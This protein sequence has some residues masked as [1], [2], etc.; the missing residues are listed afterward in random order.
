MKLL[1]T[2]G[3]ALAISTTTALAAGKMGAVSEPEVV[4]PATHAPAP[5]FSWQ[6]AY[7][8][9]VLGYGLGSSRHCEGPNCALGGPNFPKPHS[10]GLM[11]GLTLGYN[12]QRGNWVYGV[13]FDHSIARMNGSANT[14]A[15]FDCGSA[16]GCRTDISS[17][18]TLRARLGYAQGRTLFYGT[19]GASRVAGKGGVDGAAPQGKF[20][21]L[22][23]VAGLGVE[24][25]FTDRMSIKAE[26][27]H[28][29]PCGPHRVQ[30]A[31]CTAPGCGIDKI[32][33]TV[34]R[35]GLN[36]RF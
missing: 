36:I 5:V 21:T 16:S 9:V 7:G 10:N 3:M 31:A 23:P 19:A 29:L 1:L 20:W 33:V 17:M 28:T 2:T 25:A 24:H 14:T 15:S 6:G 4:P 22:A 27:L 32:S 12:L 11:G 30:S 18:T 35:V 26:V 13:E 8:G 34:A